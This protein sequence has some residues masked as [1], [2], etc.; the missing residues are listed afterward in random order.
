MVAVSGTAKANAWGAG[1]VGIGCRRRESWLGCPP[2]GFRS[3][4][5]SLA[6][7]PPVSFALTKPHH[8]ADDK[9]LAG[10]AGITTDRPQWLTDRIA[11]AK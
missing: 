7:F 11:V 3:G 10:V 5:F 9:V 4:F 6:A 1:V 2:Q 8:S